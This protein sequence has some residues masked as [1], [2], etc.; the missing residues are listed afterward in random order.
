MKRSDLKSIIRREI[1]ILMEQ[2]Q[3]QPNR[4]PQ[5]I[6]LNNTAQMSNSFFQYIGSPQ[7]WDAALEGYNQFYR[8]LSRSVPPSVLKSP[9][10]ARQAFE[11][12][13]QQGNPPTPSAIWPIVY[14]VGAYLVRRATWAG[15]GW[16]AYE[17]FGGN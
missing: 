5:R 10:E 7:T 3:N 8:K 11:A 16:I 9:Q 2:T 15:A 1:Q 14:G 12:H 6:D 17:I 13:A 4:G